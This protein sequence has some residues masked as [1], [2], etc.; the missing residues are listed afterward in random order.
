MSLLLRLIFF[1]IHLFYCLSSIHFQLIPLMLSLYRFTYYRY[2]YII[3]LFPFSSK[4]FLIPLIIAQIPD[5]FLESN[6]AEVWNI[7]GNVP[8]IFLNWP[9]HLI[10]YNQ[11]MQSVWYRNS[12]L[13]D[14][15]AGCNLINTI[16]VLFHLHYEI[17]YNSHLSKCFSFCRARCALDSNVIMSDT[18]VLFP[19]F[20]LLVLLFIRE[21]HQKS[22]TKIAIPTAP[23][24][25]YATLSWFLCKIYY[26]Y[27]FIQI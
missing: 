16:V 27:I 19:M 11:K 14:D 1:I 6:I 10:L 26:F 25:V 15:S 9:L 22:H 4:Y 20:S 7:G 8:G 18:A 24:F 5:R 12:L 21:Q 3:P 17:T 23:S 2:W 13:F